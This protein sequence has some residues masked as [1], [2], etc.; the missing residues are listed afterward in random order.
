MAKI[1]ENL[2]DDSIHIRFQLAHLFE[3]TRLTYEKFTGDRWR[4]Q[5]QLQSDDSSCH[6]T[7][8]SG[9]I[10]LNAIITIPELTLICLNNH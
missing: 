7:F 1:S 8:G 6:M 4:Q 10:K 5:R 3:R 9:E 2:N